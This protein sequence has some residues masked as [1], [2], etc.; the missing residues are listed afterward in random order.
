MS[1]KRLRVPRIEVDRAEPLAHAPLG[2]HR[3]RDVGGALQIVLRAGRD[4]AERDLFGRAAA[5]QHGQLVH[6]IAPLHQI[7]I[8]ERQLHG[9]AERAEAARDDRDL[10]HRVGAGQR[11]WRRS[12]GPTRDTRRSR[13][14][15]CSSRASFRARRSGD[16]SPRRSRACPPAVLSRRAASSAASL[17]RLARSA[18][19]NPAVR[20]AIFRRSTSGDSFTLRTWIRSTSSRPLTSGLST[21]TCRSK[22]PGTEQRRV[23]HLGPI[24]G[25]HDDDGLARIEAVHL[26]QQLIERLLALFV[27]ANR[28]LH[29]HL[30]ERVELVDEHDARR[31]RFGLREQ[32][33][34]ARRA[35]ADEH[36]D[37]LRS[38]QAEERDLGF[39]GDGAR[40]QRLAGARRP[41]EQHALRNLAAEVACTCAASSGTRR[42]R[43][44]PARPR[45]RRRRPQSSP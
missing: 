34:H 38:A 15:W 40:E 1:R 20:A 35:D 31:L 4:L 33:A 12:R 5:E 32:I 3:A 2:D 39:A 45:P 7:A 16:R 44:A 27:A 13:A 24:G 29:A 43:A 21:S 10:V 30:A 8:L 23:E 28:T 11:R 17:T 9:V 42:S 19:A 36:L 26:G 18:P 6:E 41:D 37:E 25:A 22:R 14:P